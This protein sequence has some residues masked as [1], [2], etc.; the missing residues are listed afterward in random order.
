MVS[1]MADI[2]RLDGGDY[3][4]SAEPA[5]LALLAR[6]A[7][8]AF[9]A[10]A[11]GARPVLRLVAPDAGLTETDPHAV[12]RILAELLSNAARFGGESGEIVLSLERE[13]GGLVLAVRD[14]GPGF[15]PEVAG[16]LG[17]VFAG[18]AAYARS[19]CGPGLGLALA[20]R[21]ARAIG[22]RLSL[23][24]AGSGGALVRLH[25]PVTAAQPLVQP[26]VQP[27]AQPLV[28]PAVSGMRLS[29]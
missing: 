18:E 7:L 17:A 16:Q 26:L 14:H 10:E 5:D 24:R 22:G 20:D 13:P 9:A 6:A 15:P 21:L 23:E 3:S 25:L 12:R 27:L 4:V 2:A 19:H 29:A 8:D 1:A 28:E 11:P